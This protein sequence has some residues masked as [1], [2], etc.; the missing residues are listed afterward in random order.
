MHRPT[1]ENR[2][3]TPGNKDAYLFRDV[4]YWKEIQDIRG[5]TGGWGSVA[6]PGARVNKPR[7][8]GLRRPVWR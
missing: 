8:R 3:I 2:R 1:E 5:L 7:E 6:G 4:V